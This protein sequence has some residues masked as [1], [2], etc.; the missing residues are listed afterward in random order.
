MVEI[1]DI[2]AARARLA[3]AVNET[4]CT[5]SQR[6]SALTGT[7]CFLKLENLQMTGS[8]KER[9]AANLLLQLDAA[10]RARG[11]ITA[12]A[13]NHGLAV[14]YH[15]GRLGIAATI[16]MPEWAPLVKVTSARRYQAQVILH[17]AN[18]DE[19]YARALAMAAEGGM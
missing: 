6:L 11:V 5:F 7:H 13:G 18:F 16:V 12:S 4:P 14:A 19:A 2:E 3:G 1:A 15:A 10:E 8:F 17:G 9:G